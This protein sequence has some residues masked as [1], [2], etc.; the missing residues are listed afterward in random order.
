MTLVSAATA[1]TIQAGTE[2]SWSVADVPKF[3]PAVAELADRNGYI[4]CVFGSVVKEGTG[5]DLDVMMLTRYKARTD[6]HIF[7]AEFGG[8]L[9]R[10]YPMPG[11]EQYEERVAKGNH[12]YEVRKDGRLYHFVF[13]RF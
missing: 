8:A 5:R 11:D 12:S 13:G 10:R 6:Y 3:F 9:E 7:L 1:M 2:N 4:A